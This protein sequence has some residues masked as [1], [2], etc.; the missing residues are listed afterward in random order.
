MPKHVIA[1][2]VLLAI[3]LTM[4]VHHYWTVRNAVAAFDRL[5]YTRQGYRVNPGE[6]ALPLHVKRLDGS[7]SVVSMQEMDVPTIL[8]V[9]TPECEWCER[10]IRNI[11]V[12]A[13]HAPGRYRLIG[14]SLDRRDVDAYVAFNSFTF[15]VFIEPNL[16][17]SRNYGLGAT[18]M[19][20]LVSKDG[21]VDTIWIGAYTASIIEDIRAR[22]GVELPGMTLA[23]GVPDLAEQLRSAS[24]SLSMLKA[25]FVGGLH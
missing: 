6:E 7:P 14:L 13:E 5:T 10:N 15:P 8:Y 4:N 21:H 18:P 25:G 20:F 16:E 24:Q 11:Q 17:T 22:L 2:S 3:S 23:A 19:T 12:L 9:F 1:L